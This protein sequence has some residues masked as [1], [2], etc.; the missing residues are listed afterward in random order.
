MA[1]NVND[2]Y[3]TVLLILN[4]EQRGYLTPFEFNKLATQVQLQIFEKF[5]QDYNQFLRGP[6]TDEEFAS[7]VDHVREEFQVFEKYS[8]ASDIS[9]NGSY[10]QPNDLHRFGSIFWNNGKGGPEIEIVSEREFKQQSLSPFTSPSNDFPIAVYKEDKV[11]VFPTALNPSASDI[12][13][14]YIRKPND[15]KWGFTTGS[16]GQ[17]I[18][19]PNPPFALNTQIPISSI[20]QQINVTSGTPI[21]PVNP[22]YSTTGNGSN[23]VFIFT[24]DQTTKKIAS[25]TVGT[26]IS[27]QG[28]GFQAGDV[29]TFPRSQFNSTSDLKITILDSDLSK[30]STS[31]SVNF[32]ISSSQQT[33]VILEVLK[34]AGVIIKDP[35]IIQS[36]SQELQSMESNEK[37]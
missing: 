30:L 13:F 10:L 24:I 8:N 31:N 17:Y 29:L 19:D 14:S 37:S 16:L 35:S 2:V 28:F 27:Q 6:K 7:R 33:E 34:L 20:T 15:V 32:E 9:V 18:Y 12:D 21:T 5:F 22:T 4:K 11:K 3:Q 1:I 26:N 23:A 25:I 36:A